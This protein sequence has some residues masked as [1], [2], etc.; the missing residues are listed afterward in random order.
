MNNEN[1][2]NEIDVEGIINEITSAEYWASQFG[3]DWAEK[4]PDPIQNFDFNIYKAKMIND[5]VEDVIETI[6][7]RK[8]KELLKEIQEEEE[9][10]IFSDWVHSALACYYGHTEQ[11]LVATITAFETYLKDRIILALKNDARILN[12][13]G[14]KKITV[15][16]ILEKGPDLRGNL[17]KIIGRKIN[18]DSWNPKEINQTYN[19][20]F[21]F[22]PLEEE[23]I[24]VMKEIFQ[25]R[26]IIVHNGGI[27]DQEFQS[28]TDLEGEGIKVGNIYVLERDRVDKY[29]NF[30]SKIAHRI[31][32]KMQEK[33][34]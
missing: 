25:I 16:E 19:D 3:K 11:S 15:S 29:R 14:N 22:E 31:E 12:D 6:E 32:D 7:K 13:L 17:H 28:K 34:L 4:M 2:N 21:S 24:K 18:L 9:D 27:I 33:N 10:L 1:S 20:I 8:D 23:E 30:F 5:T 26:H